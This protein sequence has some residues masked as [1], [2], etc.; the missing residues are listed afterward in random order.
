MGATLFLSGC[1]GLP[2]LAL[3]EFGEAPNVDPAALTPE[4][5]AA[6]GGTVELARSNAA[7]G[8]EAPNEFIQRF[9]LHSPRV[10]A[11]SRPGGPIGSV[12]YNPKPATIASAV[13]LQLTRGK[14]EPELLHNDLG[15]MAAT[16][17]AQYG[18]RTFAAVFPNSVSIVGDAIHRD[19]SLIQLVLTG[20]L[21]SDKI[22]CTNQDLESLIGRQLTFASQMVHGI[23]C[24][25][26]LPTIRSTTI[27]AA[28]QESQ[29][30]PEGTISLALASAL[31]RLEIT[32]HEVRAIT[33][34]NPRKRPA[35]WQD[36]S[37]AYRN[38]AVGQMIEAEQALADY[39][40]RNAFEKTVAAAVL[41]ETKPYLDDVMKRL[42]W[43]HTCVKT[44][45]DQKQDGRSD[46][47]I[48]PVLAHR[49]GARKQL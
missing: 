7:R 30:I 1:E 26:G 40:P 42:D 5:F 19:R 13:K 11:A 41:G 43:G 28:E 2:R 3:P 25:T 46:L 29:R 37:E 14:G 22:V 34:A 31:I 24:G 23:P 27:W 12:L 16:Q 10:H 47:L 9:L 38:F 36:V 35:G 20:N 49:V 4:Q 39:A 48:Q 21:P 32:G 18:A 8:V 15:T 44:Y 33:P 6:K 45:S 17:Y